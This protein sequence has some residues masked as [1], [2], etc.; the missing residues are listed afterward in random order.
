MV[1]SLFRPSGTREA[2]ERAYRQIVDHAR[3]P[4]FFTQCGVPDTIDGR[5]ELICLHAF[6]LLH[7]I[8]G[9]G[10][11]ADTFGQEFFDAMFADMDRSLR[12]MGTGDLGVG[13]QVQRMAQSFYGRIRAYQQ[14]L[15]GDDAV[16]SAALARNLYGTVPETKPFADAMAGYVRREAAE[17]QRRA[18][19]GLLAGQVRFGP[20]PGARGP[21]E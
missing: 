18:S 12:E 5:F 11:A 2:A 6:L 14:G 7:R 19:A 4:E 20:A 8:R 9:E 13:R 21:D 16:L 15:A 17:L 1:I 3:A 10:S